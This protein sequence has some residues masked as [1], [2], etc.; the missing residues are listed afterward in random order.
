MNYS[1]NIVVSALSSIFSENRSTY[2]TQGNPVLNKIQEP[3]VSAPPEVQLIIREVLQVE[4]DRL[5]KKSAK[6]NDDVLKIIKE[7]VQ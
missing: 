6:I 7:A 3:I 2:D 4:K 1:D 5:Y